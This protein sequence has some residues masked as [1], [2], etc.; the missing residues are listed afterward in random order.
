MLLA[1]LLM[2]CRTPQASDITVHV[3]T[4]VDPSGFTDPLQAQ[5]FDS[6]AQL[7]LALEKKKAIT[8][9]DQAEGA[10]LTIEVLQAGK[11]ETGN[12]RTKGLS[13]GLDGP[14]FG[15]TTKKETKPQVHAML[16]AG[17]YH[18]EFQGTAPR[19]KHAA[20]AVAD[21]VEKW[22]KQNR[23]LLDQRRTSVK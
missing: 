11:L 19:I 22:V 1:V 10:D 8:V 14:I 12:E 2:L 4:A 17:T 9:V 20:E 18:L 7:K 15:T 6:L 13:T 23:N 3:F 21:G 16:R 5:R